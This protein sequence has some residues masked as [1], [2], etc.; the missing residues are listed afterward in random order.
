MQND[1]GCVVGVAVS[2]CLLEKISH[3]EK[4][5]QFYII[6]IHVIKLMPETGTDEYAVEEIWIEYKN[7]RGVISITIISSVRDNAGRFIYERPYVNI[8]WLTFKTGGA[9]CVSWTRC[10]QTSYKVGSAVWWLINKWKVFVISFKI[11]T[12]NTE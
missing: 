7:W 9:A 3:A 5:V 11:N 12:L 2:L 4:L 10:L 6:A 8:A 1:G